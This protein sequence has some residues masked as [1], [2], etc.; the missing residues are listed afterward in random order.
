M[1]TSISVLILA[2]DIETKDS[3]PLCTQCEGHSGNPNKM[4]AIYSGVFITYFEPGTHI[5][6]Y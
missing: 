1:R 4:F 6:G 5:T 3:K 2:A